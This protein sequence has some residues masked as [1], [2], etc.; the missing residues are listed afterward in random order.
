MTY[1]PSY[2]R[3]L[4]KMGYYEYQ[5]GLIYH[6]LNQEGGWNSHQQHCRDFILKAID[7]YRP[8]K[9]TVLGSGW[10]L[11]L[12]LAEMA[13]KTG[14]VVLADIIHPPE[15]I[16]QTAG[17]KNVELIEQDLTGGLIEEVWKKAGKRTFL[18]RL[19]SLD[20][21]YIP[22]YKPV[23]DPGMVISLNIITQLE[24]QPERLL[25]KKSKATEAEFRHFRKEIQ[26]GH[27]RFLQRY[28]SI[29]I[30]DIAEVITETGGKTD[31]KVT[32]LVE[33][34]AG[35]AREDWIWDFDLLQA[36]YNKKMSV[37]KICALIL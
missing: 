31:E 16:R 30:T 20:K 2:R 34:P 13:E 32:I 11:D 23:N 9:I 25:R 14:K 37:F 24:T 27:L 29:L 33:L 35:R 10:L 8:V 17:M 3:I 21:I 18:N 28:K 22:E 15:V 5:R 4:H 26:S 12:P 6:H 36:D 7:H 1:D 19:S